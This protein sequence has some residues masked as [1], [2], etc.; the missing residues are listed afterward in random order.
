M[1]TDFQFKLFIN[2]PKFKDV[3]L[4]N[5]N[6]QQIAIQKVYTGQKQ[7]HRKNVITDSI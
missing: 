7:L 6:S 5:K 1:I 3:P 4:N 2:D